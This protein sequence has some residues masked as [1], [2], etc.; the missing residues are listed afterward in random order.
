MID[1]HCV[2]ASTFQSNVGTLKKADDDD[3]KEE[4]EEEVKKF[5][6]KNKQHFENNSF[7]DLEFTQ[8]PTILNRCVARTECLSNDSNTIE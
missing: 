6:F 7:D 2:C 8:S 1:S 3:Q 4:E 5:P